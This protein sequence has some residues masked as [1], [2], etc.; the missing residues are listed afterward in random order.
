[1]LVDSLVGGFRG[2]DD[3]FS[4]FPRLNALAAG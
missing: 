2:G 1:M 4:G 3:L